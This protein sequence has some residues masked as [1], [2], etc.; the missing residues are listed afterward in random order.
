MGRGFAERVFRVVQ[1]HQVRLP[2]QVRGCLLHSRA[3]ACGV[4]E[5]FRAVLPKEVADFRGDGELW[6]QVAGGL[7]QGL[8]GAEAEV[9]GAG[10]ERGD[11]EVQR[12]GQ[13]TA[14]V[15]RPV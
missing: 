1:E 2:A 4:K 7:G 11:A 10:V 15:T 8:M 14:F 3:Q 12:A 13:E 9:V 6:Q 5:V